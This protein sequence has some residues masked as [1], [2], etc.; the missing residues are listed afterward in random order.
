MAMLG[1]NISG[2]IVLLIEILRSVTRSAFKPMFACCMAKN[3]K[4]LL[5]NSISPTSEKL[6][7]SD[8]LSHI[9]W[10]KL[11]SAFILQAVSLLFMHL[12]VILLAKSAVWAS[13]SKNIMPDMWKL[14]ICFNEHPNLTGNPNFGT[15]SMFS[16]TAQCIKKSWRFVLNINLAPNIIPTWRTGDVGPTLLGRL[17]LGFVQVQRPSL[18]QT[19]VYKN[20]AKTD[21]TIFLERGT[22]FL[23]HGTIFLEF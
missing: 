14:S 4:S 21:G 22:I 5:K 1:A 10:I 11:I 19:S 16:T 9:A 18:I 20:R 7:M 2:V 12:M 3:G 8:K 6:S 17:T 13:N 23:E 15:K